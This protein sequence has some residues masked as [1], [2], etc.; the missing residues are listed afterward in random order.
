MRIAFVTQWFPPEPGTV[1]AAAIADGLG[2]RGHD[3]D[4]LTG[5]PNYPTGRLHDDYPLRPYRRD[6][7]SERV[8][9]HRAPLYPSHDASAVGRMANYVSFA[10]SA[11][12][13]GRRR[14]PAPDAW[15]IYSSPA[16]AALP[17]LIAPRRLRAPIHLLIQDLWP[18][19]VLESGFTHGLT[20]TAM[21]RLL[22]KFCNWSY[23]RS[24]GIGIISPGMRHILV[25][26][27]A[28]PS[29]IHLT[30]NWVED[31]HLCI[32][33]RAS[34]D[35]R[36]SLKLPNGGALFM[37]AG[38][39]GELQGLRPVIAAF[40]QCPEVSLVLIGAGIAKPPLQK[41]S[42]QLMA[43]NIHF[44]EPVASDRIGRF[45]AASDVQIVSLKDSPLLRATM[46]SKVQGAMASGR[47]ILVHAAGDAARVVTD[48]GAGLSAP[49]GD[50][51]AIMRVIR[52][53][54]AMTDDALI[55]MGQRGRVYYE[56]TYSPHVGL[57]RL[58]S[59]IAP[60]AEE[61]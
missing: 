3:V 56:Q 32:G 45:I 5:F 38:N 23:R 44:L 26:R 35:L 34:E 51:G 52:R 39:M 4:V 42:S 24:D 1:V 20:S 11:A 12:W 47:P 19:S 2:R 8:T 10:C 9:V 46:P 7:R 53:F 54:G 16:T 6:Q 21:R 25:D 14:L 18:D 58:L 30:P 15:L 60:Q 36:T 31:N 22:D 41:L 29:R 28:N 50:I 13:I 57:D 40:A 37:Y 43:R 61:A 17:A 48:C 49:P 59:M 27:G 55:K 33:L